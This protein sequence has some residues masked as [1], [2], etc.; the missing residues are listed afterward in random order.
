MTTTQ[1]P[2]SAQ[3]IDGSA[4]LTS[5][6]LLGKLHQRGID[7]RTVRH[8]AVFTVE[9]AKAIRDDHETHWLDFDDL[10]EP[11]YATSVRSLHAA[12]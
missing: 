7:I 9:Q 5:D 8:D 11:D 6:A 12:W 1:Q 3:L 2:P 4:P 10:A